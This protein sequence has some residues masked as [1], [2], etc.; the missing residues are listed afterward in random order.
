MPAARSRRRTSARPAM[1]GTGC[2]AYSSPTAESRV[3]ASTAAGTSQPP[4]ASTRIAASGRP[5]GR[6]H[7]G[8]VVVKGLA[9]LGHLDLDGIHPAEAGEDFGNAV[10]RNG[11]D[12]GVN[13]DGVPQRRGEA[14]PAGLDRGGK[15]AGGLGVAVL[16]ERA[17][18]PPAQRALQQQGFALQ[19]PA[20]F[21][22][23]RQADHVGAGQELVQRREISGEASGL[24]PEGFRGGGG[25]G[26]RHGAT[27]PGRP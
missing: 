18:F 8:G 11:R 3:S 23:H 9:A 26:A 19:D 5:R 16:G 10:C 27:V 1:S 14:Q 12:G 21:H 25:C 24:I 6:P 7:P 2:S 22:P 13:R 17:E 15:P 4:F 20:E